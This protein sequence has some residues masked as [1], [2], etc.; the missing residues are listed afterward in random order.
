LLAMDI[1]GQLEDAGATI[2]GPASDTAAVLE[3]IEQY[4]VD[5]A[6]LDA[7]LDGAPVDDIADA[8]VRANVPFAFVS[9]YGRASL[10]ASY[11]DARLLSKPFNVTE[12]LAAAARLV[13]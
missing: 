6:L 3:L 13:A 2:I 11:A 8:L 5:A 4:R 1:S 10:P 12:L 9:G 7:N